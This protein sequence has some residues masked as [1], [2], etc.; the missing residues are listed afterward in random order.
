LV[1]PLAKH[2]PISPL[3]T[4]GLSTLAVRVPDHP[5]ARALLQEFGAPIAA[6]SANPSGRLS[7]TMA[8][9]VAEALAGQIEAILDAG[10]CTLGLESTIVGL[11]DTPRLLRPGG[12]PSEVIERAIG[13]PL[14]GAGDG[15]NAPGQLSSHYAPRS[16]LRLNATASRQGEKMLGFGA[17]DGDLT[18]S[19]SGDLVEAAALLFRHLHTLDASGAAAIA[20]APVPEKGLGR[21]INDRLRRAASER[22]EEATN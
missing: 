18:L 20:V 16:R 15:I 10:D 4:G 11:S 21:A 9:H 7:P 6:P 13:A 3:V 14:A 12:L 22:H 17:V 1:L 5:G 8:D 2:A 19:S